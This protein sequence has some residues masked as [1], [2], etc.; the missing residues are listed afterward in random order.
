MVDIH[1][2]Y[3]PTGYSR[4]YPN[5]MTQEGIRGDEESPPNAMVLN[6]IFTRMIAGA[7]D[8]TNCYFA[9]RVTETMGS[10]ASQLAKAVCIYSP[11]QFLYW[12][13]RPAS[14]PGR[15]GGAGNSEGFIQEVPELAFFDALPTV[16]DD[17][18]V[19]QGY[20]GEHAVIARRQGEEWFLGALTGDQ[21]RDFSIP[22]TFL[23]ANQSYEATLYYDDAEAPGPT[24]VKI[25]SK[26]VSSGDVIEQSVLAS[27]GLAI[28]FKKNSQ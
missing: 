1:D 9:P 23:E 26:S 21:P 4:T 11:W 10:H 20:P 2:E 16:W 13:D 24:H 17:T 15:K 19:L 28:H 12:Y 3:R 14:S 7:G 5:L 25:E 6:T 18:R 8:H 22:L 27:N